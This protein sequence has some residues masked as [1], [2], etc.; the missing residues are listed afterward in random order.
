M[1]LYVALSLAAAVSLRGQHD[2]SAHG[3]PD[4]NLEEVV[5][6]ATPLER[7]QMRVASAISLLTGE[8]LTLA[9]KPSLGETLSALPGISSSYFGPGA[10][11]PVIRGLEGD[12]IRVL[13]NGVGTIDASVFSPDHAVAIDPLII[14]RVEVIRGPAALL[15]GGNAIGGAV[16]VVDHRIHHRTADR[17]ITGKAES[18]FS[19]ADNGNAQA[20]LVEG[21][22]GTVAWHLDAYR[23]EA[24]DLEIPG[25]AF[26]SAMLAAETEERIEHGEPIDFAH[27]TLPNSSHRS[28]GAAAGLSFTGKR[29]FFGVSFSGHNANYGIPPG[30]HPHHGEEAEEEAAGEEAI[31]IDLRQRRLDVQ[32]ELE[33]PLPGFAKAKLKAGASRYRHVEFEGDE[34]GTRF[35]NRGFDSRLELVQQPVNN[36]EGAIGVQASRSKFDVEGDEAFLPPSRTENYGVFAFEELTGSPVTYQFGARFDRQSIRLRDLSGAKRSGNS[37]SAS[38]GA[39][40]AFAEDWSLSGSIARNEREPNAQELFADGPHPGTARYEIGNSALDSEKST[41]AEIIL[42]RRHG[43]ITGEISLF[44]H[45]FSDFIFPEATGQTDE[46]S[47]LDVLQY[48]QRD[49]TFHGGEAELIVHLHEQKAHSLDL[50]LATDMVRARERGTSH[51]LPRI[52]PRRGSIGLQ[53]RSG[54]F[55]AGVT[56]VGVER[57][58]HLAPGEAR[59]PGYVWVNANLGYSMALG[60]TTL[61]AFVRGENL[62]D[63]EAR[64]HVSFLKEIAPLAGRNVTAGVQLAF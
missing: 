57:A 19:S 47:G 20:A 63:R 45:R 29:G 22:L 38:V 15:F 37:V 50:H 62:S 27:G 21:N 48:V 41:S 8:N 25:Y 64:N 34:V 17:P 61:T 55:S 53:F 28:D 12:R 49:V 9:L 26:S 13:S 30:A 4:H 18:R 23:R 43:R 24:D 40:W 32:G 56:V 14:E 44:A 31:R 35:S 33:D 46:D 2:H 59:T 54:T 60:K 58:R 36:L 5:I 3:H 11:R 42:R 7:D 1:K 16:N 51:S 10:S 6:S 39:V 52:T